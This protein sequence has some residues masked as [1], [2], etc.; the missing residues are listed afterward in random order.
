MSRNLKIFLSSVAGLI[1]ILLLLV[2]TD[3]EFINL[4]PS[5]SSTQNSVSLE[6]GHVYTQRFPAT[7][8]SVSRVGLYLRPQ[9]RNL[10]Q[11]A[12]AVDILVNG[13][14]RAQEKVST[15]FI[16]AEGVSEIRLRSP[17]PVSPNAEITI[18]LSVP[19]ELSGQVGI[20]T[21]LPDETFNPD[22]AHF[23]IDNKPNPATLAYQVYYLY[24]PPLAWQVAGVILV[25]VLSL[26]FP[27]LVSS[28][29]GIILFGLLLAGLYALPATLFGSLP[30]AVI[31]ITAIAFGCMSWF[32]RRFALSL[33]A[34][35]LG[36]SIFAFTTWWPLHFANDWHWTNSVL[37]QAASL[38]NIFL[39]SNQ[40]P[41]ANG[42]NFEHYG[43][44]V[45][46]IAVVL[47]FVGL[48]TTLHHKKYLPYYTLLLLSPFP[49]I[50]LPD[51][52]IIT[53]F[54]LAFFAAHGLSA[55]QKFL[56]KDALI[57]ALCWGIAIIVLL[58][59][60]HVGAGTLEFPL[61]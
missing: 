37:G 46:M 49:A 61:I 14:V 30:W 12:V 20:L 2:R 25:V 15:S 26:W 35:I 13:Q 51:L 54:G 33:P 45:G 7:R 40:I 44:Y 23:A 53:T 42:G 11:A 57:S 29:K 28:Q 17:L 32:L 41:S 55:L 18:V 58:D 9:A 3:R 36:A 24:R 6:A 8:S 50:L 48:T 39:D 21:R 56:G 16:D 43:S 19:P 47:S 38:Q 22:Y 27:G 4:T 52:I 59:L 1:A 34:L 60:F 31:L 5:P 10:T